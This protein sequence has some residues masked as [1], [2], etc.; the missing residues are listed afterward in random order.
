MDNYI[1]ING[2]KVELTEEQIKQLGFEVKK[3]SPFERVELNNEY[4]Y[5]E[6]YK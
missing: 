4:F 5:I 1:C 2:N 6:Y 3:K